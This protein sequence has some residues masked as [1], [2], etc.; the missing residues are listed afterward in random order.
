MLAFKRPRVGDNW[1]SRHTVEANA[2]DFGRAVAEE[3]DVGRESERPV[4]VVSLEEDVCN[5]IEV[6]VAGWTTY[7][8]L[9]YYWVS[10]KIVRDNSQSQGW[11]CTHAEQLVHGESLSISSISS[12]TSSLLQSRSMDS[13]LPTRSGR[14][15]RI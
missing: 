3:M 4:D 5:R 15:T 8:A 11:R 9:I 6:V 2:V 13:N 14:N 7:A 1:N 10:V 12:V